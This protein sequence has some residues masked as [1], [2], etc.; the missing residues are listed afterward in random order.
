MKWNFDNKVAFISGGASGLGRKVAQ[1]MVQ[2]GAK[3]AIVDI[4]PDLGQKTAED[5]NAIRSGHT[6]FFQGSVSDKAFIEHAV[7]D[8]VR[9]FGD[10]DFLINSAGVLRDFMVNKFDEK[11]WDFTIDVNLKGMA[12][13]SEAVVTHWVNESK[14]KAAERGEK[15]LPVMENKPR[16]IVSISSLAAEGN[17]GQV[18]YS[19][20]KAGVLGVTLTM[21]KELA[22]YNIRAH[23]VQPTLIETPILNDLLDRDEGKFKKMYESRIPFGIGQPEYV[24][25]PIC[26][27]CSEGGFFMSGCVIPI[28]GGRLEG[29]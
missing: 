3:V 12:I 11:K 6:L 21:A 19:A 7:A 9:E 24:S 15:Y 25:D 10:I 23:A 29:L 28:N 17:P 22:K 4:D 2:S 13:C 16:V 1:D 27:L 18:A 26:F 8:T 14:A 5:L 20:S